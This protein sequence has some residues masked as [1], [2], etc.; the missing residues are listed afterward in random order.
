MMTLSLKVIPTVWVDDFYFSMDDEVHDGPFKPIYKELANELALQEVAGASSKEFD[1]L[2]VRVRRDHESKSV[3]LDQSVAISKLI[4]KAGMANCN[5]ERTPLPTKSVFTKQDSPQSTAE[6]LS[7]KDEAKKYRSIVASLN[8]LA[9]WTR[10]DI[11]YAAGKL[12]KFMQNPGPEHF[13]KLKRV[14]R[15]LNEHRDRSLVFNLGGTAPSDKVYG[16]YDASHADDIDTRRSTMGYVFFYKGCPISW[17]SKL[18]TYVTLST[19]NSEY[20]ASAKGAREATWIKKILQFLELP[21]G[22]SPIDLFS[23]SAGA[24]AMNHNPVQHDANKHCDLADHYA[25]EQVL[26]KII[27][28][29]YVPTTRMLADILTKPLGAPDFTKFV[30][31]LMTGEPLKI[32]K[33]PREARTVELKGA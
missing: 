21:A 17:K 14:L 23:D 11:A 6:A 28:I 2:G 5:G 8:Y 3:T 16:Y 7:I 26:R 9:Q 30:S 22:N 4:E 1:I 20:C 18:H 27:T 31:Q 19:N 12:S 25:R 33:D 32:D 13:K 10:I 24:I 29:S 15:Y